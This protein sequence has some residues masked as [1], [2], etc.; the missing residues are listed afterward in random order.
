MSSVL[1]FWLASFNVR[2]GFVHGTNFSYITGTT[3]SPLLPGSVLLTC[4]LCTG[5]GKPLF[6]PANKQL[7]AGSGCRQN[8]RCAWQQPSPVAA[9]KQQKQRCRA[10]DLLWLLQPFTSS[11]HL[12]WRHPDPPACAWLS[13]RSPSRTAV[14]TPVDCLWPVVCRLR[15]LMALLPWL[16]SP[17][18]LERSRQWGEHL[19]WPL[20]LF[21]PFWATRQAVLKNGNCGSPAQPLSQRFLPADEVMPTARC[22]TS[23]Q[24]VS[25]SVSRSQHGELQKLLGVGRSSAHRQE[26]KGWGGGGRKIEK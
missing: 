26:R 2:G 23:R 21:A 19:P 15:R 17:L 24:R 8:S 6:A 20:T 12:C 14:I 3:E 25:G 4:S 16:L 7:P 22:P 18:P 9:H 5:T 10:S 13:P 1:P 11:C